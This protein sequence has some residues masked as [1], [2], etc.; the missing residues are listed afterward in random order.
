LSAENLLY[1]MD[2]ARR[3]RETRFLG[4][5]HEVAKMAHLDVH[6]GPILATIPR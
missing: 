2:P 1:D 4:D 6:H 3:S 5:S